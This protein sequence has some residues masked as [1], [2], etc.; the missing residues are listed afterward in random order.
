MLFNAESEPYIT[1][2]KIIKN[3]LQVQRWYQMTPSLKMEVR[4]G[5]SA[6]NYSIDVLSWIKMKIFPE[7]WES[8]LRPKL[9]KY[10]LEFL[11][12]F[13]PFKTQSLTL[14]CVGHIWW[15]DPGWRGLIWAGNWCWSTT[16]CSHRMMALNL[17][18]LIF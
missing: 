13:K 5:L 7:F 3:W 12:S 10:F 18:F 4:F 14:L 16:A 8:N 2:W 9:D 1:F 15:S 17:F 11:S 6:K